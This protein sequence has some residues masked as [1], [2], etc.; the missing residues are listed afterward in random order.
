KAT[1][2]VTFDDY[3]IDST[4]RLDFYHTGNKDTETI[5]FEKLVEEGMW[6][7]SK[8]N[9]IDDLNFGN[10]FV[11]VYDDSTGKMI[12]SRGFST[13]YQEWQTTEEARTVTRSFSGS[14]LIPFPKSKVNV[15]I[16]RR[17]RRNIFEKKFQKEIDPK[18]YF[19]LKE[20]IKTYKNFKVHYSGD[21]STKLDIVFIP[22]GYTKKEMRKFH[23]DSE[24]FAGYLFNYSP[25]KENKDKIN[26]WGIEAPSKETGTD[27]PA[28]NI[29]K[30]TLVNSRF[31]TLDSERYLMTT[32]YFTVRDVAASAPYDQIFV[33]V[34]TTKYG[35]GAIYNF[36]SMT[37][38]DNIVANKIFVHEFA[39]GFGGLADE[40]GNDNTYQNMYPLD[41]EPWEANLT[42]LVN[43][44]SKWMNLIEPGTPIPTPA[45]EKYKNKIGV[46]E[47]GGY[48]SKGVY[49]PTVNSIMN[50]FQSNEFNQVCKDV[51]QKIIS[52]YSE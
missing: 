4:L 19:I 48:V 24:R 26:I 41:V 28:E 17:N 16:Y 25:F 47:G 45:E 13:L 10:Y 29:W 2:K 7:G 1:S 36:Y 39:H 46:F 20:K 9:L 22:E 50:S 31:Y 33:M 8:K 32:D 30:Q 40:Y 42:T 5:S 18:D 14:I 38:V 12:Y 21:P 15:E 44:E 49:R 6:S 11:N 37:S 35:G 3:F 23:K 27:I 34:N 43:F 52:F 51:L